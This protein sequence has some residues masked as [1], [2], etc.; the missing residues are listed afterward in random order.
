MGGEKEARAFVPAEIQWGVSEVR[1]RGT[2][3]TPRESEDRFGSPS[4]TS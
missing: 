2:W 3:E 1:Q 4:D